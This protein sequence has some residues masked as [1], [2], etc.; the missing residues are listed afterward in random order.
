MTR[1]EAWL[2]LRR[3]V[4]TASVRRRA[5]AVEAIMEALAGRLGGEPDR[6]GLLGLL[7]ELDADFT[8]ANPARRGAVAEDMLA[9]AGLQDEERAALRAQWCAGPDAGVL[10]RALAAAVPSARLL[11]EGSADREALGALTPAELA[12]L[13]EDPSIAPE[14]SRTRVGLL[15]AEGLAPP[16]LLELARA[17]LLEV[18]D[19]LF[20][21]AG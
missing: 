5:L 16:A 1:F 17:R 10:V 4:R 13:V 3:H 9:G 18:E 7:S 21:R 2:L 6:W 11:L 15:S 14:A 20:P 8:A 19:E 12:G